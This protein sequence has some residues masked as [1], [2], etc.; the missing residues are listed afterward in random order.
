MMH[1]S[2]NGSACDP[3]NGLQLPHRSQDQGAGEGQRVGRAGGVGLAPC[4]GGASLTLH[5]GRVSWASQRGLPSPPPSR[6]LW[7]PPGN[8]TSGPAHTPCVCHRA[9][10]AAAPSA[11]TMQNS[12]PDTAS[13]ACIVPHAPPFLDPPIHPS[14]EQPIQTPVS[15]AGSQSAAGQ[16]AAAAA[17]SATA[18]PSTQDRSIQGAHS[19][20]AAATA[21]T[22][23]EGWVP[24]Q[25]G[26]GAFRAYCKIFVWLGASKRLAA[27]AG[28]PMLKQGSAQRGS[29][30]PG[31]FGRA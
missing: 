2:P 23:A 24:G 26:A 16:G 13:V 28:E 11:T 9:C 20:Q 31:G 12:V 14:P 8:T 19:E 21:E 22:G 15:A 3:T 7:P 17:G 30:S 25:L 1:S 5:V 10:R 4:G 18:S 6:P 27:K 29:M